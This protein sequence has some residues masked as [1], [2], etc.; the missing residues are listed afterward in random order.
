MESASTRVS[1]RQDGTVLVNGHSFFPLG[2]YHVSWAEQGGPEQRRRDME[3]MARAGFNVM[4]TEPVDDA[5][6]RGFGTLLEQARRA[7]LFVLPYGLSGPSYRKL[8]AAP[9]LLGIKIADDANALLTWQQARMKNRTFKQIAPDKLTYLSLAVADNRTES[10]FFSAADLIGNQSYPI[11]NDSIDA[12]Y[13]TM[14]S[15]VQS[16][17][18]SGS[19]P[20]ANLQSFLW[21]KDKPSPVEL[22]N[23]TYQALIAGVKGIVYYAYRAKEIDLN[24]EPEMWQALTTLAQEIAVLAPSLTDGEWRLLTDETRS[25][26][27]AAHLRGRD[28]SGAARSFLLVLNTTRDTTIDVQLD[29]PEV[30]VRWLPLNTPAGTLRAQGQRVH[31]RLRPLQVA[32]YALQ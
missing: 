16:A 20:V 6:A 27:L 29:L 19:V 2:F 26:P 18:Q 10:S 8:A 4:V 24:R 23:M 30:P 31:G 22:R 15:A 32:L 7:G 12:T 25:R 9:A 14:R 21:E 17:R 11:G 5:D 13:R 1:H 28:A 3:R